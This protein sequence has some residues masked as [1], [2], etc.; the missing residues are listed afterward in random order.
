MSLSKTAFIEELAATA[1]C[2]KKTCAAVL[3]ALAEVVKGELAATGEVTIPGITKLKAK[4]T[5]ARKTR[6]GI[7][8]FTKQQQVFH[9]KPAGVKVKSFPV[10]NIKDVFSR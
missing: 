1:G 4:E 6:L 8:P 3:A 7:N 9:S 10:K 5:P 2:D